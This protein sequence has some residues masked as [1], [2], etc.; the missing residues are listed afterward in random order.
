[1][2]MDSTCLSNVLPKSVFVLIEMGLRYQR[3]EL[4]EIISN[5]VSLNSEFPHRCSLIKESNLN[6]L[7]LVYSFIDGASYKLVGTLA[8][9]RVSK[10]S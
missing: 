7:L 6:N 10:P 9:G 8:F 1:M 2:K 3:Q 5:A 4:Q